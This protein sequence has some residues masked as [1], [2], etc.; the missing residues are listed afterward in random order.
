M[1]DDPRPAI[2][3]TAAALVVAGLA[4]FAGFIVAWAA[5]DMGI[6]TDTASQEAA[7]QL[8]WVWG[9]LWG[10][11]LLLVAGVVALALRHRVGLRWSDWLFRLAAGLLLLAAGILV[12]L[13]LSLRG[14]SSQFLD[15]FGLAL[16]TALL[17]LAT[18]WWPRRS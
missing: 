11:S 15:W 16:F 7:R 5:A 4:F 6:A 17:A 1:A 18:P 13:A 14:H 9:C 10:A 12:W 8:S 2:G 3:R